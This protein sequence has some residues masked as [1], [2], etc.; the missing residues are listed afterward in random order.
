MEPQFILAL[1]VSF[2]AVVGV[3]AGLRRGESR[4]SIGLNVIG[5]LVFMGGLAWASEI[6]G[7]AILAAGAASLGSLMFTTAAY[8][9]RHREPTP[10]TPTA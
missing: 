3:V 4:S 9:E 10:L 6:G 7:D 8:R 5:Y 2:L 1:A